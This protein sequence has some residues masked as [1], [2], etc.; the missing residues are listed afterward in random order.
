[1]MVQ[2][3]VAP[4]TDDIIAQLTKKFPKRQRDV[5]WPNKDRIEGLRNLVEKIKINMNVDE[6]IEKEKEEPSSS[7]SGE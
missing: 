2:R 7:H 4:S 3:G 6:H 5:Q 1:M